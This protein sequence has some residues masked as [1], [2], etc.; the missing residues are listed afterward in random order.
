M[1]GTLTPMASVHVSGEEYPPRLADVK[2]THV[3]D[4]PFVDAP[5]PGLDA[6]TREVFAQLG[7]EYFELCERLFAQDSEFSLT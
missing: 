7:E 3:V 5:A 4:S 6:V 1:T 2:R